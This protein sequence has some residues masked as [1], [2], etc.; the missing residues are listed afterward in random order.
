[1][2][3]FNKKQKEQILPYI[4]DNSSLPTEL[5][6]VFSC[7]NIRN[8]KEHPIETILVQDILQILGK[9]TEKKTT[10]K[11]RNKKNLLLGLMAG[12]IAIGITAI[13]YFISSEPAKEEHS[14]YTEQQTAEEQAEEEQAEES[15]SKFK[16]PDFIFN[17]DEE[18]RSFLSGKAF[19][20]PQGLWFAFNESLT[21]E[22][23]EEGAK[24][25]S[26]ESDD[27]GME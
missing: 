11:P 26:T 6:F 9:H 15:T 22:I 8:I 12:C 19:K 3:A 23:W 16:D 13:I 25:G 27:P 2:T 4:I 14:N 17:T 18:V 7:I 1:M 5:E 10:Q 24:D 20:S 21:M